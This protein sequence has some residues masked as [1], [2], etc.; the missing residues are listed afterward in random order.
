MH[1]K[2][3]FTFFVL[4]MQISIGSLLA[5]YNGDPYYHGPQT[6][7]V[8]CDE[9]GPKSGGRCRPAL[10]YHDTYNPWCDYNDTWDPDA[11]VDWPTKRDESWIDDLTH[12]H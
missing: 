1:Q 6:A 10:E 2:K 9:T 8:I 4:A 11:E 5:Q 3:C 7:D 12:P